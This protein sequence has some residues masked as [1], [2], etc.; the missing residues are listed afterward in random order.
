VAAALAG[1]MNS[2]QIVNFYPTMGDGFLLPTLAAV[3]VGGTSVF[4][5]RGSVYGTFLGAFMIGAIQAGIVA[6]GLTDYY[7]NLIYGAVVLAAVAVHAVLRR[8]FE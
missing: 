1:L 6:V 7:T 3:F 8:R 5:G 2:L 4:G